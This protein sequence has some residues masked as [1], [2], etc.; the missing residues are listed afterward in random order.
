M[1]SF[2]YCTV[3]V[4]NVRAL[5]DVEIETSPLC[6][7]AKLLPDAI[8]TLPPVKD[9][10]SPPII[11]NEPPTLEEDL[12]AWNEISPGGVALLES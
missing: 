10:L 11:F 9:A 5:V 4:A 6:P 2:W 7:V 8:A 12:P 1:L 3:I